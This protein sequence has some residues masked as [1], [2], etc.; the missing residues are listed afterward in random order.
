MKQAKVK[1]QEEDAEEHEEEVEPP[2]REEAFQKQVGIF[3]HTFLVLF[4][5]F[6]SSPPF[7][8]DGAFN[9]KIIERWGYL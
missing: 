6:T 3:N 4:E 1:E 8:G 9:D 7:A 2:T 5:L